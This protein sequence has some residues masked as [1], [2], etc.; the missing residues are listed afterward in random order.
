[1]PTKGIERND[2][3]YTHTIGMKSRLTIERNE[4]ES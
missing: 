2:R 4:K 1:M 3:L